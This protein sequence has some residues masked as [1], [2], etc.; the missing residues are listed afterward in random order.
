MTQYT[1]VIDARVS[2]DVE[3]HSDK[4]A[5][6]LAEDCAEQLRAGM[7]AEEL[8]RGLTAGYVRALEEAKPVLAEKYRRLKD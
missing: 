7:G 6:H 2:F 1:F 3:A 8:P 4:I 5:E